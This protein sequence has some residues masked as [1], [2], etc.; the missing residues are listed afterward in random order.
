MSFPVRGVSRAY[1][2]LVAKA[3]KDPRVEELSALEAAICGPRER[4]WLAGSQVR[5]LRRQGNGERAR[6]ILETKH[7]MES[8]EWMTKKLSGT[9]LTRL[10]APDSEPEYAFDP[11]AVERDLAVLAELD[12]VWLAGAR[13]APYLR[14]WMP[15]AM[16]ADPVVVDAVIRDRID[17]AEAELTWAMAVR[18]QHLARSYGTA[19]D[20]AAALDYDADDAHS[21]MS[22]HEWFLAG[23]RAGAARARE[24]ITVHRPSGDTGLPEGRAARLM[25]AACETET[26]VPGRPYPHPLPSELAPWHV[27]IEEAGHCVAVA[28]EGEYRRKRN[29]SKY[30]R[31]VPVRMLL[32]REWTVRDGVVVAPF[33]YSIMGSQPMIEEWDD[34]YEEY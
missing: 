20:V 25:T 28:V 23:I 14:H 29:P 18:A 2:R 8:A 19:R 21:L 16:R 27:Y 32:S 6:W 7:A 31:L 30:M 13:N 9:V 17:R 22:A 12:R 10:F 3:A 15:P 4:L 33:A 24:T 5:R 34:S 1:G 26:V 11:N